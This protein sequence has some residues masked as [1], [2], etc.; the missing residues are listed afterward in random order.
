MRI[1]DAHMHLGED[2]MFCSDDSEEVLLSTMDAYGIS[3]QVVQP[4]IVS[5]DQRRAHERIRRF[6]EAP[7]G[8]WGS[9]G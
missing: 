3:A 6:A 7:Y 4:G 2:L 8:N 5:R 9:L 1:I